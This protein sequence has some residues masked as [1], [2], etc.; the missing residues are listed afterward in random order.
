MSASASS[1]KP[2]NNPTA[3]YP[4]VLGE[5]FTVDGVEYTPEDK[6]NY[7]QVGFAAVDRMG[8]NAISGS[9]RT[10]P[11][12]SY[13]E[14]TSL[15][16]GRTILVRLERRGMMYGNS[17]VGLSNGALAQ[18]GARAGAPVRVRRVLPPEFERAQLRGGGQAAERMATPQSLV[19]VLKRKLPAE[20]FKPGSPP[21]VELAQLAIPTTQA[22]DNNDL[23]E[24]PP[25][26]AGASAGMGASGIP[27]LPPLDAVGPAS[28][29]RVVRA[30]STPAPRSSATRVSPK[31]GLVVQAAAFA[32][33]ARANN[34][35][36]KVSGKVSKAG[37]FYRVRTGPFASRGEAESSLAKV[38]AA[39]YSDAKIFKN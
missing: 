37:R 8:G 22:N 2:V 34:A 17:E 4:V 39:G 1:A 9:H 13:V 6:L 21:P 3:D 24:L 11:L 18:L 10:M 33:Q 32:S 16:S 15:E 36:S 38:R 12:P 19:S 27:A 14:I 28:D 30:N 5:P 26:P 7:D 25:A 23:P 29:V 31:S 20:G 35:A